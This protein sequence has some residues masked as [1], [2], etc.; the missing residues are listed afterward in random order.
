MNERNKTMKIK[1]IISTCI[2][3]LHHWTAGTISN[4]KQ[5]TQMFLFVLAFG[6]LMRCDSEQPVVQ[7][8]AEEYLAT[9]EVYNPEAVIPPQCYTKTEG[10]NNPCYVCHQSY[11]H[12]EKRP[13]AMNDGLIQGAYIFSDVGVTN[14]WKNLFVDRTQMINDI[15]DQEILEYINEDNYSA[16]A[17]KAADSDWPSNVPFIKDLHLAELAF[18]EYGLA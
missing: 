12:E 8:L 15:S 1:L 6:V 17:T 14:S 7:S 9:G 2:N 11:S 13:N 16:L 4:L 5:I 18:D 3:R 10:T